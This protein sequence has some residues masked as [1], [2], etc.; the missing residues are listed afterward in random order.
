MK[1]YSEV[2]EEMYDTIEALQAAEEKVSL[3]AEKEKDVNEIFNLVK[4]A[5]NLEQKTL[6]RMAEYDKKY[7]FGSIATDLLKRA[8]E[9]N[10]KFTFSM[11]PVNTTTTKSNTFN[12]LLKDFLSK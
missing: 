3:K 6:K 11:S 9:D 10:Q 4:E 7:G 2:T 12:D 5:A 1:F 8:S